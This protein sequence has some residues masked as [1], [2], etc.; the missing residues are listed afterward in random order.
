MDRTKKWSMGMLGI[1][2]EGSFIGEAIQTVAVTGSVE[3]C[4][5]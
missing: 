4:V 5:A 2:E 1:T 3:T